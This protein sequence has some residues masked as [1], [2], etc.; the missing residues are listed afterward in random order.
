[1]STFATPHHIE[2]ATEKIKEHGDNRW[3]GSDCPHPT[4][5]IDV[6]SS[7]DTSDPSDERIVTE[8]GIVEHLQSKN[9]VDVVDAIDEVN[10]SNNNIVTEKA[11]VDFINKKL[12]Q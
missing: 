7:I 6:V 9:T 1:M 10:P 11:I 4:A 5:G 3:G 12:G 8:K 2:R